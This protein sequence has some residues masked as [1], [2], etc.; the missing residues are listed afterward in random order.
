[1]I[2]Y[3]LMRKAGLRQPTYFS[4]VAPGLKD[5]LRQ[6][7]AGRSAS[8][9]RKSGFYKRKVDARVKTKAAVTA[10]LNVIHCSKTKEA[11]KQMAV[12]KMAAA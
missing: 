12:A 5:S 8:A 1:M 6:E 10:E 3:A 11:A 7:A 2:L 4:K 9:W